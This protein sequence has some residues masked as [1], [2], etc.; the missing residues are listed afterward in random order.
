M[1]RAHVALFA[2]G[3]EEAFRGPVGARM[4]RLHHAMRSVWGIHSG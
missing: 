4:M 2:D 3:V 1:T